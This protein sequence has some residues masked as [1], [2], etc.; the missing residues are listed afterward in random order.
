[1]AYCS[2]LEYVEF[3]RKRLLNKEEK[4]TQ[5]M[6]DNKFLVQILDSYLAQDLFDDH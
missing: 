2:V 1:M 3:N 5:S 4:I 6:T